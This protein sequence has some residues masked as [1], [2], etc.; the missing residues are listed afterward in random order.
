MNG[1]GRSWTSLPGLAAPDLSVELE[2]WCDVGC[3][4]EL[5]LSVRIVNVGVGAGPFDLVVQRVSDGA[6]LGSQTLPAFDPGT[7]GDVITFSLE[8]AWL[9]SDVALI[10]DAGDAVLECDEANNNLLITPPLCP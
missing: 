5:V 7:R 2:G 9:T 8:A 4:A 10:V 1:I 3:P 6:T